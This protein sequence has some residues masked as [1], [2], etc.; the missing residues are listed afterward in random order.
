M[1]LGELRQ[2][3]ADLPDS[4][5]VSVDACFACIGNTVELRAIW[6]TKDGVLMLRDHYLTTQSNTVVLCDQQYETDFTTRMYV[7]G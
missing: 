6:L 3:T 1:T 4:V 5:P 2:L 7:K